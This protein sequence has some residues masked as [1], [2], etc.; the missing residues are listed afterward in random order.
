VGLDDDDAGGGVA[1][2]VLCMQVYAM[3]SRGT[4]G[5]GIRFD[6]PGTDGT[7][8]VM[9]REQGFRGGGQRGVGAW[10]PPDKRL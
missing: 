1:M 5:V 8:L 4:Q 9:G 3:R 2:Y 6:C 7:G 10:W